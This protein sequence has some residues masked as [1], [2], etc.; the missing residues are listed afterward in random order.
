MSRIA[1]RQ[2]GWGD[3]SNVL[4]YMPFPLSLVGFNVG[5]PSFDEAFALMWKIRTY[6]YNYAFDVTP[7]GGGGPISF[8]DSGT[9]FQV[10]STGDERDLI[11]GAGPGV[12][13]PVPAGTFSFGL[14][15]FGSTAVLSGGALFATGLSLDSS[16]GPVTAMTFTFLGISYPVYANAGIA[17]ATGFF[18]IDV[19][20]YWEYDDGIG[21]PWPHGPI[22]DAGTGAQVLFPLPSGM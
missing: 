21:G 1:F 13:V 3:R 11:C 19:D 14:G 7:A 16:V 10:G 2:C 4:N 5:T 6:S 17:S 22:W 15:R 8:V 20:G 18:I 9:T 12:Q